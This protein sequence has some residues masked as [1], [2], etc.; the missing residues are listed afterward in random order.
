MIHVVIKE[1][2]RKAPRQLALSMNADIRTPDGVDAKGMPKFI[3]TPMPAQ[4]HTQ[5]LE[6]SDLSNI[7]YAASWDGRS[8]WVEVLAG[9]IANIKMAYAGWPMKTKAQ[10]EA[11]QPESEL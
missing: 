10:W 2:R 7:A 6:L 8:P 5:A 1:E 11:E 3:I 4:L 9:D